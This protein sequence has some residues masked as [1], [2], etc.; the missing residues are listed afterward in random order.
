[1]DSNIWFEKG[2]DYKKGVALYASLKGHSPNLL[3][4]FLKKQS[5]SNAEKLKYELG[6]FRKKQRNTNK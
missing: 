3:R 2:C 6:K 1:M 5:I 4:L